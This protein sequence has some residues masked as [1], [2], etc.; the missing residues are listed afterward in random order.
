[1]SLRLISADYHH[2]THAR[3]LGRLLDVYA[4]D[5]M[6]RGEPLSPDIVVRLARELGK[7]PHAFSILAYLDDTAVGMA[8]CFMGFSTF[9]CQPLVNIHDLA[10]H[11]DFRHQGIGTRILSAVEEEARKRGCCKITLEVLDG[12]TVAKSAY[13]QFGFSSYELDPKTGGALFWEKEL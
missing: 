5:E 9:K 13:R 8:N 11:P 10:V 3:D 2:P 7:L 4:R 12:N 6:G 1:M